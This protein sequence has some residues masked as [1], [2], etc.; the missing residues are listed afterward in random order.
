MQLAVLLAL[1]AAAAARPQSFD[2]PILTAQPATAP[3]VVPVLKRTEV[4][5]DFN[6]LSLSYLTGD[7]TALTQ[8]GV[9]RQ[10][11]DGEYRGDYVLDQSGSYRYISPEGRIIMVTYTADKDGFHPI[12]DAIP[13]A[14]A[15]PVS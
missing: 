4:R 15:A 11:Q 5:D 9:L 13:V 12:S 3:G 7:G 14:P 8:H 1:A 10:V 2:Q 6:Q